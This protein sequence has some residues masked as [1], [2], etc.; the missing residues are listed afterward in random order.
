M[1]TKPLKL[2]AALLAAFAATAISSTAATLKVGDPAPPLQ[3]GKW[4]QGEPVKAF[5]RDH[6]YLV[7]FWATWCGPCKAAIPHLNA[8]HEKFKSQGFVVIGQNVWETSEAAVEPFVKKMGDKMTYRVALDDKSNGGKGRMAATWLA[9]AGK[10]GIPASFL[11]DKQGAV[12][13]IGHPMELQESM[14]ESVLAGKFAAK[15]A[16]AAQQ[17]RNAAQA[18]TSELTRAA[19]TALSAKD[20]AKAESAIAALEK[21][22]PENQQYRAGSLRVELLLGQ[23]DQDAA[24]RLAEQVAGEN[25][26]NLFAQNNL[27]SQLSRAATPKPVVLDAAERIAT[28]ANEA[29]NGSD[30]SS[31]VT[32]ARVAFLKGNQDKAVELQA[33]V[34]E[35]SKPA[36][37]PR[38]QEFLDSYKAGK[39]PDTTTTRT[40][41]PAASRSAA[42]G[43]PS[44]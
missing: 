24:A 32:L 4:V 44:K 19:Y 15:Q 26:G 5:D 28:K 1:H 11:V 18:K 22:L 36:A 20:W 12:V 17:D 31:L 30:V 34:V 25:L 38:M 7:E 33:K 43:N 16:I 8:L 2:T 41:R 3:T 29:L 42:E 27:A 14:I 9:A 39:L 37:K 21:E 23:G 35:L 10:T 40:A 6:A 13:W